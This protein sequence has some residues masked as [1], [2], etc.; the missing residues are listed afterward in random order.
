MISRPQVKSVDVWFSDNGRELHVKGVKIGKV[1]SRRVLS[2]EET[3]KR[4]KR[5]RAN[6]PTEV[7]YR[8]QDMVE[9]LLE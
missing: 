1:S 5:H 9:A 3:R 6:P 8:F 7:S 4:V 2:Q